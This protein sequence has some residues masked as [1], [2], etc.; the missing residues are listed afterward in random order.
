MT[1]KLLALALLVS[2]FAFIA[3][4]WWGLRSDHDDMDEP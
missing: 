2:P 4:V 3:L 1:G